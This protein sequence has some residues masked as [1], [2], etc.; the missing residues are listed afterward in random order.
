VARSG[1]TGPDGFELLPGDLVIDT[2][3]QRWSGLVLAAGTFNP[4]DPSEDVLFIR[5]TV[6]DPSLDMSRSKS[7]SWWSSEQLL[8]FSN[9]CHSPGDQIRV[10]RGGELAWQRTLGRR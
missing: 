7:I 9:Y 6:V 8:G 10:Y 4:D 3:A 5:V 2:A 1:D